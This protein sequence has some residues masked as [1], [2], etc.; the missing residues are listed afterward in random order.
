M[1]ENTNSFHELSKIDVSAFTEKKQ[2]FT[3]LSWAWAVDQLLRKYPDSTWDVHEYVVNGNTQPFMQTSGGAFVK[4]SVTVNGITRSQVHPV[5]DYKNKSVQQPN[6][7]DVNKAIQRGLA[8]AIALHGLGLYIFAGEDMPQ[9]EPDPLT[10]EQ[11]EQMQDLINEFADLRNRTAKEVLAAL[12]IQSPDKLTHDQ[13]FDVI[14]VLNAW[15]R[16]A[17]EEAESA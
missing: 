12:K 6:A 7:F 16:K 14:G 9:V 11:K 3:Y 5:L 8:K 17:K 10:E 1:S 4:V 13:A 2:Q 15:I